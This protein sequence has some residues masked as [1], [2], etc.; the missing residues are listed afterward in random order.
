MKYEWL[1]PKDYLNEKVFHEA[2][3]NILI[4]YDTGDYS[5]D[6]NIHKRY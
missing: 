1:K 5:I 4:N 6:F 3:N 2:I